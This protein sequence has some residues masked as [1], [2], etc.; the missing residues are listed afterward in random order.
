MSELKQDHLDL[1][2][3]IEADL[4]LGARSGD[5]ATI[6]QK[7]GKHIYAD[8]MARNDIPVETL[9]K[10]QAVETDILSATHHAV[11]RLGIKAMQADP[12]LRRVTFEM[13]T[14]G[15]DTFN[16][17]FDRSR[18]VP[19]RTPGEGGNAMKTKYGAST[20]SVDKYAAG[21]R[22]TLAQVKALLS[23]E[24]TKAFGDK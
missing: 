6:T 9:E 15:K 24:A 4:E 3:N 13:P 5:S 18:Q 10:V 12:E 20:I 14:V 8:I 11:G 1:S 16:F 21:N 7:E 2:K 22:G 19:D 23:E 17:T